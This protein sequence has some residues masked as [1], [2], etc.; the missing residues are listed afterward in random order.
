MWIDWPHEECEICGG[1]VRVETACPQDPAALEAEGSCEPPFC[2]DGDKCRC[3]DGH[4]GAAVTDGE[5]PVY[6]RWHEEQ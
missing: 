2:Y 5:T 1:A 6:F 4:T 3:E